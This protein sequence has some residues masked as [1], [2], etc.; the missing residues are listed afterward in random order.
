MWDLAVREEDYEA[1]AAYLRRHHGTPDLRHRL[2]LAYATAD[3]A[4]IT[5]LL[6]EARAAENRQLQIA[7]RLV[8]TYLN[9]MGTAEQLARHVLEWR[10]GPALRFEGQLTIAWLAAAQGQWERASAALDVAAGMDGAQ[11][12]VMHRAFVALLPFLDVPRTD[13][14]AARETVERWSA[15]PAPGLTRLAAELRPRLRLHLLG[16]FSSR[17]GDAAEALRIAAR[18]TQSSPSAEMLPVV[19]AMAAT[20]RADVALR[21]GRTGDALRELESV[22]TTVPLELISRPAFALVREHGQEHA[23]Y[24]RAEALTTLGRDGDAIRVWSTAFQN[25][26]H[27]AAYSPW[28]SRRLG[29]LYQR[30]GDRERAARHLARFMHLWEAS[31]ARLR[32]AV[33]AARAELA[34]LGN[35]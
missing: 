21:A 27:E 23:R 28:V 25:A 6:E 20:V 31:D 35:R 30:S 17:L 24:L 14:V 19:H 9:D 1:A 32:P 16:L 7:S 13:L 2:T 12:V 8:A 29:E 4:A 34:R 33:D 22:T 5:A 15:D 26:P 10:R 18:I 11:D 3:S